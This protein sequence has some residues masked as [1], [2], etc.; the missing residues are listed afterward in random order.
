[1][2]IVNKIVDNGQIV[3]YL[4]DSG[5]AEKMP[6]PKNALYTDFYMRPLL[7]SGYKYYSREANDITD[8]KGNCIASLPEVPLSI[9]DQDLWN[10]GLDIA[11]SSA[12]S[13]TE[14][15]KYYSYK[16]DSVVQFR[17]E[18][19]YEI[20]TREEFL[21][22]LES[23]RH[24]LYT[25]SYTVDNRPLGSF[26]NPD[27]MFTIDEIIENPEYKSYLDVIVKRHVFRNYEAYRKLVKWLCDKGVLNTTEP[28]TAEFLAAY[29]AWGPEG[30]K[31][32]C[33][34]Y[35]LKMNVDGVFTFPSDPLT[36]TDKSAYVTANRNSQYAVF[37]DRE[38][39]FSLKLKESY[40]DVQTYID[41]KRARIA[42]ASDKTLMGIKRSEP[43]GY[44]YKIIP[45]LTGAR[46][47]SYVSDVSDRVY[48][49]IMSDAG[50]VYQYKVAHNKLRIGLAHANNT[51][52]V[53]EN[54]FGVQ[55]I[56]TA[57]KLPLTWLACA[58]D[59]HL[60]N[61]TIIKII[62][63]TKNNVVPTPVANTSEFLVRDG[64][65]PT[66]VI[67][68][69]SSVLDPSYYKSA[70]DEFTKYQLRDTRCGM[71]EALNYFLDPIP[72]YVLDAFMLREDD[73][74]NGLQSFIDL[75]DPEDLMDRREKMKLGEIT[76]GDPRYDAS[77]MFDDVWKEQVK[78][79]FPFPADALDIYNN[80]KF[81]YDSIVGGITIG[82]FGDGQ[83]SDAATNSIIETAT[84]IL[85][86]AY[87]E[88]GTDYSAMQDFVRHVEDNKLID[89]SEYTSLRKDGYNGYLIDLAKFRQARCDTENTMFYCYCSKIFREISNKPIEQQRPYLM[90]LIT[91]GRSTDE[92]NIRKVLSAL[93]NAA[94]DKAG[95]SDE[96]LSEYGVG[97]YWSMKKCIQASANYVAATLFFYIIAGRLKNH[98]VVNNSYSIKLPVIGCEDLVIDLPVDVVDFVNARFRPNE[99]KKYITLFDYCSREYTPR[100]GGGVFNFCLVNA[101]VTPW[102]INPKKGFA[103]RS[104]S[105]MPNYYDMPA[106]VKAAGEEFYEQAVNN[107]AIIGYTQ[108]GNFYQTPIKNL[109]IK[110]FIIQ[111]D[112]AEDDFNKM[113]INNAVEP[114]DLSEF[115]NQ[116]TAEPIAAYVKRWALERKR[117][118]ALGK[119]LLSIPLKQ[120]I[121]LSEMATILYGQAPSD[122]AEYA[123]TVIDDRQFLTN[124]PLIPV[125]YSENA[126]TYLVETTKYHIEVFRPGDISI[127]VYGVDEI[128]SGEYSAAIPVVVSGNNIIGSSGSD[129]RV[130][131]AMLD[132]N[133]I[134]NLANT[135][136]I[137]AIGEDTFYV[138]AINGDYTIKR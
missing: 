7:Q 106:L 130:N 55:S 31:S 63:L 37:N 95:I 44:K 53:S 80:I 39:V 58:Q 77:Y 8:P 23:I 62:T 118:K 56:V 40:R 52:Y 89:I 133:A 47:A 9:V 103:I 119:Q 30:I 67:D 22:Y 24:A 110:N 45:A 35:E 28:T 107:Q 124:A 123:D 13:D 109:S 129:I 101:D 72:T 57:I 85:S 29:Y 122:V 78:S 46:C 99:H 71:S 70:K 92:M 94:I 54:N 73:L 105:M 81:A 120:D 20:N 83:A 111:P 34:S 65:S 137:K 102:S 18:S 132:K 11:L 134:N 16:E 48:F 136:V 87:A 32:K 2:E 117:A 108:N 79:G 69:M 96:P 1:M 104:Y 91:L 127:D 126:G 93:I 97:K 36:N 3:G 125:K 42:I 76:P 116:S 33:T 113:I 17:T 26:V 64:I 15:S 66:A 25:V 51:V 121:V 90:E 61:M 75:A 131:V 12:L 19:S 14:A 21:N 114:E 86:T 135:G 5:Y 138:K 4:I 98:E 59:Y 82:E 6:C 10:S 88:Y 60:W 49:T 27:A 100:Q 41:L 112:D 50:Y 84:I 68:Y 43:T 115:M 74:E 38:E 128:L